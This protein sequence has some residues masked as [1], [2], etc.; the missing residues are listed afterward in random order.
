LKLEIGM[1]MEGRIWKLNIQHGISNDEV[2][3]ESE[4]SELG[5]MWSG[6]GN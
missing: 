2:S 3:G 5:E 4:S 1:E 6:N